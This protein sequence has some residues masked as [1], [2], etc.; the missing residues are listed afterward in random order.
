MA[1]RGFQTERQ[2]SIRG[3]IKRNAEFNQVANAGGTVFRNQFG[4]GRINQ[5][6]ASRNRIR[7]VLFG[8]VFWVKRCG[9]ASLCPC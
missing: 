7:S 6:G 1:V 5:S 4:D 8:A 3:A 9:E 2:L